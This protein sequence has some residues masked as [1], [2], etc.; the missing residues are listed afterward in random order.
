MDNTHVPTLTGSCLPSA[1]IGEKDLKTL[2]DS[3]WA[4]LKSTTLGFYDLWLCMSQPW[5]RS[6]SH[7][8]MIQS[9]DS[10]S[11]NL[12]NFVRIVG[13]RNHLGL[14]KQITQI[15]IQ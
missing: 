12:F 10:V 2:A 14:C 3:S 4:D 15:V 5:Y 13:I 1:S 6:R 7:L 8:F 9:P 11:S